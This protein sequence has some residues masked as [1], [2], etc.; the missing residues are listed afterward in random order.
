MTLPAYPNRDTPPSYVGS[1]VPAQCP[2]CGHMMY[3]PPLSFAPN[4]RRCEKCERITNLNFWREENVSRAPKK[5]SKPPSRE[6][7]HG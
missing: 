2:R 5:P 6:E 4:P 1:H 7:I 3:V